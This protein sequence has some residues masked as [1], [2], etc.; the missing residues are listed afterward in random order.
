MDYTY[1]IT[2]FNLHSLWRS[3]LTAGQTRIQQSHHYFVGN[4]TTF[5]PAH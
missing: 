5:T 3:A 2:T 4:F 1:N